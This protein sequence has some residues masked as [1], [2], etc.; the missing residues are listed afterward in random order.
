MEYAAATRAISAGPLMTV[1]ASSLKALS[2]R[3]GSSSQ[4][5]RSSGLPVRSSPSQFLVCFWVAGRFLW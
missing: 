1:S 4:L 2:L 3:G 5:R